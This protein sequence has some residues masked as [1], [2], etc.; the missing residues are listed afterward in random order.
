MIKD[1][2]RIDAARLKALLLVCEHV[3]GNI[4]DPIQ[5][6]LLKDAIHEFSESLERVDQASDL[7]L[8]AER[9]LKEVKSTI[10]EE[11]Q[12]AKKFADMREWAEA[13]IVQLPST[14]EGRGSWL[15]NY[16]SVEIPEVV[17]LRKEWEKRAGRAIDWPIFDS[18]GTPLDRATQKH[19]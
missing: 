19:V 4:A 8:I 7:Q 10:Q 12:T 5:K 18:P 17:R 1:E 3:A 15:L 13:L 16:G 11:D 9:L 2:C 6:S 14:H